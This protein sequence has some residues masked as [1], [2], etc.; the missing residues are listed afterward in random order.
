MSPQ[1]RQAIAVA[2]CC[3]LT[4]LSE[5]LNI[6]IAPEL[7]PQEI[8]RVSAL[9]DSA[10]GDAEPTGHKTA[11]PSGSK[12]ERYES[13]RNLASTFGPSSD[14]ED[15]IPQNELVYG[16]LSIDVLS[17]IMDAVGVYPGERFL[18]IGAGDGALVFGAKLLYPEYIVKSR[19]LELVDGLVERSQRHK[20][21]LKKLVDNDSVSGVEFI[22]G[23]VHKAI[24]DPIL[25]SIL[26]DTTLGVCFATTWSAQNGLPG[27]SLP[28]LSSALK[29]LPRK[30]RI[31]LVDG[32][33][34]CKDGYKWLG[35]MKV[36]CPDT[37][38]F[39]IVSLY[40]RI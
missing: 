11:T 20:E 40:E 9:I 34:D 14:Q 32:R 39:S 35:D 31:V 38:P 22:A 8:K 26:R 16:E 37:A 21:R 12:F 15:S 29:L 2:T 23:D 24:S 25:K 5:G 13:A 1:H 17:T 27:R 36:E 4:V 30:A 28:K 18:D 6:G 19:G 7:K 3:C 10:L 33:L